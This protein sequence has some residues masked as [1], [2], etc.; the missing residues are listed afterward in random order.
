MDGGIVRATSQKGDWYVI[1]LFAVAALA[2]ACLAIHESLDAATAR[3]MAMQGLY[4]ALPADVIGRHPHF[5][6]DPQCPFTLVEFGDYECGPCRNANPAAEEL[7]RHLQGRVRLVFR[8]MP[9]TRIHP[10][11]M[12]AAVIAEQSRDEGQFWLVHDLLYSGPRLTAGA[13][14][15]AHEFERARRAGPQSEAEARQV[16]EAD[17][18]AAESIGIHGTPSFVLCCPNGDVRRIESI[19]EVEHMLTTSGVPRHS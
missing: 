19:D 15:R 6:G 17:I 10:L 16:V 14:D 7:A 5:Q 12:Q 3:K 1:A 18:R 13:M 9:L 2:F 8:N 11:A 4:N